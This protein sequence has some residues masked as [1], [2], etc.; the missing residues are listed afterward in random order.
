M[1]KWTEKR[2]SYCWDLEDLAL[3][4]T[5]GK[6]FYGSM[7]KYYFSIDIIAL[8]LVMYFGKINRNEN[9][10]KNNIKETI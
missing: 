5:A 4:I 7:W 8:S 9:T 2:F 6:R 1:S 10:F 3:G